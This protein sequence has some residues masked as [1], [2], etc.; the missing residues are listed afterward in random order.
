MNK[1]LNALVC[2]HARNLLLA[3]GW[4]EETDI[5]QLNPHYPAGSAFM[6]GWMR[7]G[8]RRYLS[9]ATM[10]CCCEPGICRAKN[11]RNRGGSCTVR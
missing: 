3:Q 6:C 2:R 5:E 4:P 9:T 11:D 10:A 7:P 8:W 1:T